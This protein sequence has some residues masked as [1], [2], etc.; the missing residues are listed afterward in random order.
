MRTTIRIDPDL[1]RRAKV[2]AARSGRTVSQLIKDA[3]RTALQPRTEPFES[4]PELPV[5]GGTGLMP[6]IKNPAP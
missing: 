2:N 6:R 4:A 3:V 1:Y 5:Y